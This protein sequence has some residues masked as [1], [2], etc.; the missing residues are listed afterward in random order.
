MKKLVSALFL[1]SSMH[2]LYA[3]HRPF[4]NTQNFM[5]KNRLHL[6][7]KIK[8][9]KI[10]E[11]EFNAR[12]AKG[13]AFY[14][15][16]VALHGAKLLV[17][18]DWASPTVNAYA[19]QYGNTWQIHI[20]G[21]ISRRVT[22]DA[23]ELIFCHEMGHH[24][25]GFPAQGWAAYE[26]Q[27]DY[28][29]TISCARELW[30]HDLKQNAQAAKTIPPYPK[31]KC[32]GAWKAQPDR[33][34]CYRIMQAGKS[35]ADLLSNGSAK[36]E[37]SDDSIVSETNPNHPQGQCRLDTYMAGSLCFKKFPVRIIPKSEAES[38]QSVCVGKEIG[39]RPSCWFK[40]S[41]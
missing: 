7:D 13:E 15:P 33:E 20:Y 22:G 28:F 16:I 1:L 17:T 6:E 34:L 29:A 41:I 4:I 9:A 30:K 24:L 3:Q 19:T 39:A 23:L 31:E 35:L 40:A 38:A 2:S 11:A 32:D 18:K 36:Y 12:L 21:G 37:T 26:G 5:P 8:S 25:A 27:S 14:K 10:N